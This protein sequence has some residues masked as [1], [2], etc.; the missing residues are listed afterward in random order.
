MAAL[1]LMSDRFSYTTPWDTISTSE[2]DTR[3]GNVSV[4]KH[5]LRREPGWPLSFS[6]RTDSRAPLA[7]TRS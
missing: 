7:G 4:Y 6:Y 1:Y 5:N 2:R 3:W